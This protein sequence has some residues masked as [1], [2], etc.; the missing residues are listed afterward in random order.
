MIWDKLEISKSPLQWKCLDSKTE[1]K[2]YHYGRFSLS[3]L[4]KGQA[5]TIAIAIRRTL[6]GEVE[7]TSITYAKIEKTAV[8]D[9]STMSGIKESVHDILLNL[10][11]I[12]LKSELYGIHKASICTVGPRNVT[13]QD[14]ILPSSIKI[15]DGTQ[16]I[17][18]LTKS[19]PFN[20]MLTIERNQGYAIPSQS[21]RRHKN[22]LFP[23]DA[24]CMPVRNVNFSIHSYKSENDIREM[25]IFEIWTNGGLTPREAFYEACWKLIDLIVP[26]LH[27]EEDMNGAKDF[28]AL[29]ILTRMDKLGKALFQHL[30]MNQLEL[31]SKN[32]SCF[33]Q[34]F[35][36]RLSDFLNYSRQ[37][38][39]TFEDLDKKSIKK[40][41]E[42]FQKRFGINLT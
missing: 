10:K 13:A 29:P 24:P 31:S 40:I 26:L 6:L 5:N 22:G 12:V 21:S 14:I 16:H 15:I 38:S 41:M 32:S 30:F 42:F 35:I 3:P 4:L 34:T 33:Q 2:R 23:I 20:V 7:G 11:E 1:S 9:Y 39:K 17:A 27:M 19:V 8:H 36:Y 18:S 37:N 28:F 25:L